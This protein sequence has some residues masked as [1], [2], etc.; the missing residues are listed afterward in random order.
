MLYIWMW[1]TTLTLVAITWNLAPKGG[2]SYIP[3]AVG[4]W[5]ALIT[6]MLEL[7]YAHSLTHFLYLYAIYLVLAPLV[8]WLYRHRLWWIVTI[9]SVA[10][11]WFGS[12]AN[13]EWL[14]W[15]LLFFGASTLGYYF[16][17]LLAIYRRLP[18]NTRHS[19]RMLSILGFVLTAI[20]A[21]SHVLATAPG[22]YSS[23][24]YSHWPLSL[25]TVLLSIL[26]FF[27]LLSLFTYLLPYLSRWCGWLLT[28]GQ[29]SLT[30]YIL[31]VVPLCIISLLFLPTPGKLW[32]NSLLTFVCI[33]VT[34]G[35]MKIPGINYIIP[36]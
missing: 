16:D 14:Q 19:I 25:P 22:E 30:A 9:V 13:I 2:M 21:M 32:F 31:H 35:L 7:N 29:R 26:W 12:W 10:G 27:G 28:F 4:D 33:A 5:H 24:I 1:I 18:A 3:V 6:M 17:P 20:Y 23:S 8:I 34:W 11:Y 36:R 15:Q